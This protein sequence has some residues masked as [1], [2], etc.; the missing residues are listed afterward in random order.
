MNSSVTYPLWSMYG[1]GIAAILFLYLVF[2]TIRHEHGKLLRFRKSP[3]DRESRA[4]ALSAV[5]PGISMVFFN[6]RNHEHSV[7]FPQFS[8]FRKGYFQYRYHTLFDASEFGMPPRHF[9]AGDFSYKKDIQVWLDIRPQTFDFSY[10]IVVHARPPIGF[11]TVSR[12][13][14]EPVFKHPQKAAPVHFK[15]KAFDEM[16]SVHSSDQELARR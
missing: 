16:F 13:D 8:I 4:R 3:P 11:V 15:C 12:R 9:V 10:L 2:Q 14:L 1:V 5:A 7:D 6:E